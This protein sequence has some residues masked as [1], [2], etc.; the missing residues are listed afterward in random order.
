MKQSLERCGGYFEA[1]FRM[2]RIIASLPQEYSLVVGVYLSL[3]TCI[4]WHSSQSSE[5]LEVEGRDVVS[6]FEWNRL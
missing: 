1:V 5:K 2:G 4:S 6:R 3:F